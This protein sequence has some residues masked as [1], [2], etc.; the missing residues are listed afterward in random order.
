MKKFTLSLTFILILL[1]SAC[2]TTQYKWVNSIYAPTVAEDNLVIDQGTCN[3][4]ANAA[5]PLPLS[6]QR[7]DDVYRQCRA[8]PFV[9]REII[10]TPDYAAY[11]NSSPDL[12]RAYADRQDKNLSIIAWGER[13]YLRNG[14]ANG[15]RVPT[16]RIVTYPVCDELQTI[17]AYQYD[18]YARIVSA[19][20]RNRSEHVS[21]CMAILG[22]QYVV[23]EELPRLIVE[24]HDNG[25]KSKEGNMLDGQPEGLWTH[26]DE[27]GNV[28]SQGNYIKG[29]KDGPWIE[30]YENGQK[31]IERIFDNGNLQTETQWDEEGDICAGLCP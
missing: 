31:R 22:W 17:Q 27:G 25:Q 15:R 30:Y 23:V 16:T 3:A 24:R 29:N 4:D 19:Q 5:F 18:Q 7:P 28:V 21:S 9:R 12:R 10:V 20:R 11:V 13:H 8:R 2:K 1:L 14:R 6:V 26:W